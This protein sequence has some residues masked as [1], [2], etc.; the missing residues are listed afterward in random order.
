MQF[1]Y[2]PCLSRCGVDVH[3]IFSLYETWRLRKYVGSLRTD[4]GLGMVEMLS[5]I[6]YG[7]GNAT[8]VDLSSLAVKGIILWGLEM[9]TRKRMLDT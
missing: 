9:L 8:C 2:A 1:M 4:H 7:D 6:I 3:E 5:A